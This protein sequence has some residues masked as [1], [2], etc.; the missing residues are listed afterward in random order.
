MKTKQT[1]REVGPPLPWWLQEEMDRML[2][3]PSAKILPWPKKLSLSQ[4]R[5]MLERASS[6]LDREEQER[7]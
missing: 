3:G 5:A 6:E 4:R 1:W 7:V 2:G